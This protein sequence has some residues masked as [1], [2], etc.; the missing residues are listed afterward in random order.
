MSGGPVA[1]TYHQGGDEAGGEGDG[2]R[3]GDGV[4]AATDGRG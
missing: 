1:V 3:V 4:A 2:Q